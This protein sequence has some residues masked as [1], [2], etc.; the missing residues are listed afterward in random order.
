MQSLKPVCRQ[1]QV[2]ASNYDFLCNMFLV[3]D[4]ILFLLQ[5]ILA[6]GVQP[7][8]KSKIVDRSFEDRG[9][10][11][12]QFSNS[13]VTR[14]SSGRKLLCLSPSSFDKHIAPTEQVRFP[15]SWFIF[16]RK[17]NPGQNIAM[18]IPVKKGIQLLPEYTLVI[19]KHISPTE[20]GY[21]SGSF[22]YYFLFRYILFHLSIGIYS[23][24]RGALYW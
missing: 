22:T 23:C 15:R 24:S 4:A 18:V 14:R 7:L 2:P 21:F 9:R 3:I 12:A 17:H 10:I 19:T 11:L 1:R 8:R 6:V 20:Q 13:I 5:V 16:Y